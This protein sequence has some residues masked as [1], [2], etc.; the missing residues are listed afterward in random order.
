MILLRERNISA[1]INMKESKRQCRKNSL[2]EER[3]RDELLYQRPKSFKFW[4]LKLETGGSTSGNEV[5]NITV[6]SERLKGNWPTGD[7]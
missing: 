1:L 7:F 5:E 3:M 4:A 6:I 2:N